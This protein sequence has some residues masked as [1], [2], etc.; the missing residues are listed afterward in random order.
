MQATANGTEERTDW[1][2]TNWAR[3]EQSVRNLRQRIFRASQQ[4]DH[5]K[6]ASLQKLMLRSHSNALVSVRRVTQVNAGK[7]TPGVDK[8]LVKT[9]E[10]RARLVSLLGQYQPWRVKPARRVYIPKA[11]GKMR[12]LGIPT[13]IDRAMQAVMKNA[14]EPYWEAQFE[15]SSYGFRPGRGCHDAIARIYNIARPNKRK[16]WV[17]DADIEGA[18]DNI[19]HEA[20]LKALGP[21]PGR[22]LIRQWLKAGYVEVG[23]LHATEAGTPQGGVI[24]PLLA[25]IVFHGMEKALGVRYKTQGELVGPRALVRY[26]DDFV[27]FCESESDAQAAKAEISAWFA[28]RGLRLSP[29]KT[30]IVHLTDGFDFLGYNIRHYR[31]EKTS[32]SG[33]KLLIKPSRKSQEAIRK[34]LRD[35]WRSLKGH[36]VSQVLIRLNPIIRGWANYFR[37]GVSKHV[38]YTLDAFMFRRCV[39]YVKHRHPN[40]SFKWCREKYWGKL[41]R[42]RDNHW[43][44]GDK[45]TNAHLLMFGWTPIV[46]HVLIQGRASPDDPSLQEYWSERRK[47]KIADLPPRQRDLAKKQKGLCP[48]CRTPLVNGEE[49]HEHHQVWRSRGGGNERENIRLL[50]LYCH[51]QIHGAKARDA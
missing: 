36:N 44:F 34:K 2:A 40:K 43:V 5:R 28:E 30:R 15:I 50:H 33:W 13:M 45:R 47:V 21:A 42:G 26:A 39:R 11:N 46:R 3:A 41:R 38:F 18:F 17:L 9:P 48:V 10:E 20:L 51:Q 7:N 49:L 27:V 4:G 1:N 22:E 23:E 29:S 31:A 35:E 6:A 37:I 19:G 16:K 14:L 25:N 12:P 24:S 32:R 8:V